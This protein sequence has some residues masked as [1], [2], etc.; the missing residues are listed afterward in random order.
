MGHQYLILGSKRFFAFFAFV[1]S[2]LL[3][4]LEE[5]FKREDV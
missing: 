4:D 2:L 1:V 3:C 5:L